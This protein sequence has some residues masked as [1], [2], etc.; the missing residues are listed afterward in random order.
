MK[1]NLIIVV[2]AAVS[3]TIEADAQKVVSR[4][5]NKPSTTVEQKSV[6]YEDV[7]SK[8]GNVLTEFTYHLPE[9][10]VPSYYG[11]SNVKFYFYIKK[12][13]IGNVSL[14]FLGI[15]HL[16]LNRTDALMEM[17]EVKVFCNAINEMKEK[18]KIPAPDGATVKYSYLGNDGVS[19]ELSKDKWT[20]YLERHGNDPI[21]IKDIDLL[22]NRLQDNIHKTDSI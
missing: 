18:Q 10:E 2:I 3:L 6:K 7:I 15:S 19:I 16:G 21:Y 4:T 20:I 11:N 8:S 1:K 14:S 13:A 5:T 9:L 22:Y 12:L 17:S